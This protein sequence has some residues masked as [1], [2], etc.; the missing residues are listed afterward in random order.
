MSTWD[1]FCR[2]RWT[3][4]SKPSRA[5]C[6]RARVASY[7]WVAAHQICFP[8][9]GAALPG[10]AWAAPN[11]GL[12]LATRSSRQPARRWEAQ[13]KLCR[14]SDECTLGVERDS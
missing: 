5:G 4:C 14:R 1:P 7:S 11:R 13:W 2:E 12:P 10:C 9:L 8:R 6:W 3:L